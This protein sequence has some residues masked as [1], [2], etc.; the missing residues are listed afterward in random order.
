MSNIGYKSQDEEMNKL[1]A[2]LEQILSEIEA[3]L[4][5]LEKGS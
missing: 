3:R 1:I 2:R 4:D 5:K